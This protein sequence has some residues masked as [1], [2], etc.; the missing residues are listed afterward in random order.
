MGLKDP[1]GKTVSIWGEDRQIIGV[2]KDF[3]FESL[4]ENIR[5]CFFDFSMSHRFTFIFLV[6]FILRIMM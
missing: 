2:T 3:H 1:I 4:Y 6:V 5:P